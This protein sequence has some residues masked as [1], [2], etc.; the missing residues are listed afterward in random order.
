MM[1][2]DEYDRA[3][4]NLNDRH[5]EPGD[6]R[7]GISALYGMTIIYVLFVVVPAVV[8]S[9]M[10][11]SLAGWCVCSAGVLFLVG[12]GFTLGLEWDLQS[13]EAEDRLILPK[14]AVFMLFWEALDA[15][16]NGLKSLA[17]FAGEAAIIAA[18]ILL[19]F[20][21]GRRLRRW[22]NQRAGA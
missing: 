6:Q 2:L 12:L 7:K 19:P 1:T 3:D 9:C 18:A 10:Y 20:Y 13:T 11:P 15:C 22:L 14:I 21:A 5:E 4:D 16:K 17:R 8:L